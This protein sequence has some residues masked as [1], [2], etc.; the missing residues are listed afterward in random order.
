MSWFLSS[1]RK[2]FFFG[3]PF[4]AVLFLLLQSQCAWT[5]TVE[6]SLFNGQQGTI[7]LQTSTSLK[8]K[9]AH[10]I[11]LPASTV[12]D[13]LE[14]LTRKRERGLL[15]KLLSLSSET[16]PVFSP[17]QIE[18]LA[19]HLVQGLSKATPEEIVYFL[20]K[21]LG[22]RDNPVRGK[23]AVFS[24]GIFFLILDP[25]NDQEH[26]PSP[27]PAKQTSPRENVALHFVHET[28]SLPLSE[29]TSL[30]DIPP[31]TPWIAIHFNRI[32]SGTNFETRPSTTPAKPDP[33]PQKPDQPSTEDST[34]Q[35]LERQVE[36]LQRRIDEQGQEIRRL[37]E[38]KP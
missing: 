11:V 14:G 33:E 29:A 7:S 31:H 1:H 5:P 12:R 13:L 19:P 9:P 32:P 3:P 27:V 2:S 36:R 4:G 17:K 21:P 18:F 37:Q 15:D 25:A 6:T 8:T 35:Q 28:T 22:D 20:C 26:S 30:M 10:P 16:S 23:V 38:S 24:P 34:I